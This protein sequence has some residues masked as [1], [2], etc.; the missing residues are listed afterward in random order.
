MNKAFASLVE[1]EA[2]DVKEV[3][4]K[5]GELISITPEDV[6][7]TFIELKKNAPFSVTVADRVS[8]DDHSS[9]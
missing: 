4:D 8:W 7:Q 1:E 5:L 2:D 9:P 6:E 3:L